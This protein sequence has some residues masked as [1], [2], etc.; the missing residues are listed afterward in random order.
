MTNSLSGWLLL[1]CGVVSVACSSPPREPTP[2][3][4]PTSWS[5]EGLPVHT[6]LSATRDSIV[7]GGVE[8]KQLYVV[9]LDLATG[10]ER[11]RRRSDVSARISGVEQ[12]IHTDETTAY[13][14]V[15]PI[16]GNRDLVAVE[17]ATGEQKWSRALWS[18]DFDPNVWSCGEDLCL[19]AYVPGA[20]LWKISKADGSDVADYPL[21]IAEGRGASVVL[22]NDPREGDGAS[23]LVADCCR[24]VYLAQFGRLGATRT[25]SKPASD[26]FGP[27]PVNSAGGWAVTRVANGWIVWLGPEVDCCKGPRS[28]PPGAVAGFDDDG[29][30]RWI[31]AQRRPC[32]MFPSSGA[33]CDG[34]IHDYRLAKA[35]KSDAVEGRDPLTGA[36]SWKL[37][38]NGEIDENRYADKIVRM[39]ANRYVVALS[40]G[41]VLLDVRDGPSSPPPEPIVGWCR[42]DLELD[43][44]KGWMAESPYVR[45]RHFFPCRLGAQP[46]DPTLPIPDF[47]GVN[48]MGWSAWVVDGHV[49]AKRQ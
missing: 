9:A 22:D 8:A 6:Q 16:V 36:V 18:V 37:D 43:V 40:T 14:L 17:T 26:L 41:P 38:L 24:P 10:K 47:A 4:L 1:L 19:I 32:E 11:W 29:R 23:L 3:D 34:E 21:D 7:Y 15:S 25:W 35:A 33:L 49:H 27:T 12:T 46:V 31:A 2:Q 42:A 5:S 44:I 45:T 48:A 39:D 20:R 30:S 28:Y 13:F